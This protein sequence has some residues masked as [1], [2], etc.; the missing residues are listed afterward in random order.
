MD[1]EATDHESR[2]KLTAAGPGQMTLAAG[3]SMQLTAAAGGSDSGPIA[4]TLDAYSG[5]VMYPILSGVEWRGPVV[6]DLSGLMLEASV[7]VHRDHDTTRPVGHATPSTDSGRLSAIGAFSV[8]GSDADEIVAGSKN[9]F[10][11]RVSVGLSNMQLERIA[12]G[13]SVAVNGREFDGPILVVR[14]AHLDELSFVTV[15]GD[16]DTSAAIAAARDQ[17]HVSPPSDTEVKT[18]NFS[19]WIADN[20]HDFKALSAEQL[21][22]LHAEYM[23]AI[24]AAEG[25]TAD[26]SAAAS[27]D[28]ST[29]ATA[30]ASRSTTATTANDTAAAT[31]AASRAAIADEEDRV[32]AIR[33]I[34]STIANP[35]QADGA[36]LTA[37]A[38][39]NGWS[40]QQTTLAARRAARPAG[41]AIHSTSPAQRCTIG[42]LQAALLLRAGR[43][44]DRVLPASDYLPQWI[45]RPVNDPGRDA[46]MNAANEFRNGSL[47][48]FVERSLRATGHDVPGGGDNRHA[49][50]RAAFSTNSIQSVFNDSIGSIAIMAYAEAGNFAA[51]WTS[52]NDALNLLPH[53]RPRMKAAGDL[54][55]H[56]T[57]GTATHT[58]REANSETIQVD[59]YSN[60]C[61]IDENDFINDNF[62]LLAETPRDFGRAAARLVPSLVAAIMLNNPTLKRTGR[63]LF[64]TTDKNLIASNA[65]NA[66]NLQTARAALAR[67]KDGDA[68]LNLPATHLIV[69]STLGDLAVVLTTS[70]ERSNDSG[71]GSVNPL[72]SRNIQAV[73]EARLADGTPNP[74]TRVP[75]AGSLTTY[76]LVSAEGRTIEVQYLQG[77]GQQPIV[78]VEPLRGTGEYGLDIS[79]KHFAGAAPLDCLS[80]IRCDA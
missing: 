10:P 47:M 55:L 46:I 57:G 38:I 69:P 50:L 53:E 59:R 15:P 52:T 43:A 12:A 48:A 25:E 14:G 80:M 33:A 64:N 42:A 79:V 70:R 45:T 37:H 73:E 51:G 20:G 39:R 35:I 17:S 65:L 5:G 77:T 7:P 16:L 18:V 23:A 78:D 54:L 71:A 60:R 9:G 62:G 67:M 66:T 31:L 19:Q 28:T 29:T 75:I 68:S 63:A 27:S 22:Q 30:T 6:I 4:F 26:A 76:Y 11:W 32:E 3:G 56:P 21:D 58:A 8:P 24:D 1:Y 44:I 61:T 49:V 36:T 74:S 13:R 34:G 41:P 40:V 72:Y 2:A